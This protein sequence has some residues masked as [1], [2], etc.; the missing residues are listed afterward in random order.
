[1]EKNYQELLEQLMDEKI[2]SLEIT[3]KEFMVF[4]EI[5]MNFQHRKSIVGTAQRGGSIIYKREDKHTSE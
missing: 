3:P 2:E 1:M 5:F 4:Q